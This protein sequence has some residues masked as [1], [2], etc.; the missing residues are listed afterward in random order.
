[1]TGR[2]LLLA[3]DSVTVQKVID[4][5]FSDEGMQVITVGDGEQAKQK[6]DEFSPDILLAD[7]LMP[8]LDGYRLCEFVKRSERFSQ[9][10]VMLLVGSFEPFD[11]AEARRVGADDFVT[12]P[13][14]SIRQLVSRVGSLL[15]R[16]H[17][18]DVPRGQLKVSSALSESEPMVNAD[19]EDR[20]DTAPLPPARDEEP[21]IEFQTADTMRFKPEHVAEFQAS[22]THSFETTPMERTSETVASAT[23]LNDA[24]L[25]LDDLN[26]DFYAEADDG[27]LDLEYEAPVMAKPSV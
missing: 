11:E 14:Q 13:F 24:L 3:D 16:K 25:D 17:D 21:S 8:G 22:T 5:T 6:L 23:A 19:L 27:I 9:I 7:V 26:G 18:E 12:K 4:L 10:P 15:G 1:M 20:I 2:K